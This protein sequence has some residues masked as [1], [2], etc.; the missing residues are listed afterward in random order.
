MPCWIIKNYKTGDCDEVIFLSRPPGA[1]TLEIIVR[2]KK[3]EYLVET[4]DA[5]LPEL[6]FKKMPHGDAK[7]DS[8]LLTDCIAGNIIR[9]EV[10]ELVG[11]G[12]AYA[13]P[14]LEDEFESQ[15]TKDLIESEGICGVDSLIDPSEVS[16]GLSAPW[17][18]M[19]EEKQHW[20][21]GPIQITN[22]LGFS[23]I[24]YA[25]ENGSIFDYN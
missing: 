25:D 8:I 12:S 22:D 13:N 15:F 18:L 21:W 20:I 4:S 17:A 16:F 5:N 2:Y 9:A 19:P 24:I 1:E 11:P 23:K 14:Y 3:I 10:K 6:N 7:K